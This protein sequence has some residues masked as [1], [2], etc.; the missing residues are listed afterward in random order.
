M[1]IREA[2]QLIISGINK[3]SEDKKQE[4]LAD[5]EQAIEFMPQN[6]LA[7]S[8]EALCRLMLISG[9]KEIKDTGNALHLA[10]ASNN[11]VNIITGLTN[12][13]NMPKT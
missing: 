8:Y 12:F 13:R 4:A 1:N 6:A 9:S 3:L 5:F 10:K 11:L 7:M 2:E